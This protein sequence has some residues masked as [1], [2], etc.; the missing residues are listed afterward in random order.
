MWS[1]KKERSLRISVSFRSASPCPSPSPI[2]LHFTYPILR[3]P[4]TN[5]TID[6]RRRYHVTQRKD[7][8]VSDSMTSPFGER[9]FKEEHLF[10]YGTN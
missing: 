10:A 9:W 3:R 5:Y 6:F 8:N 2:S 4:T 1:I 7:A